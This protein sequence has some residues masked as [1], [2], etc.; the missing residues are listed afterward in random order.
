VPP[1]ALVD[2]AGTVVE[3]YVYDPYGE[4]T[5]Y[6]DDWSETRTASAEENTRLYIGRELDEAT[7]LYYYRAR[8][9]DTGTGQFTSRDPL[10]FVAGD[11][12]LYRYVGN[13]PVGSRDPSGLWEDGSGGSGGSGGSNRQWGQD[14]WWWSNP[15][16]YT[17]VPVIVDPRM[18][19]N[20]FAGNTTLHAW[21]ADR[22][23]KEQ[24]QLMWERQRD[25]ADHDPEMY[26]IYYERYYKRPLPQAATEAIQSLEQMPP[27]FPG[28]TPIR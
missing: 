8:W 28:P 20:I 13:R 12:N 14:G 25:K 7:E 10:G 16:S 23:I 21:D 3:R 18:W 26:R 17:V 6:D 15:W 22:H 9:Y 4:V 1:T 11:T 24:E 19:S 2:A 27:N 5:I